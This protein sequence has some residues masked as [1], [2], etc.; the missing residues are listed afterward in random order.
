MTAVMRVRGKRLTSADEENGV[1][2]GSTVTGIT[3]R[4][5]F[6]APYLV[7]LLL[8]LLLCPSSPR[9]ITFVRA[10]V[11]RTVPAGARTVGSIRSGNSPAAFAV[12]R[13]IYAP[14]RG[15]IECSRLFGRGGSSPC[16]GLTL[17]LHFAASCRRSSRPSRPCCPAAASH[18]LDALFSRRGGRC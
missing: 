3:Y 17:R 4:T 12:V 2:R 11:A 6:L 14:S 5:L 13:I 16:Y 10:R 15:L 18:W 8:F 9:G 1:M 7:I